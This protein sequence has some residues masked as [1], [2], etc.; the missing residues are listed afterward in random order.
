LDAELFAG[1]DDSEGDLAA[2]G[3]KDSFEHC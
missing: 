1:S 3:N 2:I